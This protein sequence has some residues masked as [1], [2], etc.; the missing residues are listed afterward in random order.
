VLRGAVVCWALLFAGLLPCPRACA[1]VAGSVAVVSDYRFRGASLS[2]GKPALQLGL[3]WEREDGW[4]AGAFASSVRLYAHADMQ[5]LAYLGYARRLRDG[6]SWE[7]GAEYATFRRYSTDNYP[8]LYVGLASER[9]SG[10]LYYAPRYFGEDDAVVYVELNA[11]QPL[12]AHWRL[13]GHVGWLQRLKHVEAAADEAAQRR[14]VDARVGIGAAFGKFD[15]QLARIASDGSRGRYSGY[16]EA[17]GG[18]EG[19]WVLSVSR[20]W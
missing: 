17:A 15:L 8:E 11:N 1:Q 9:L 7:A 14:R 5:L 20:A 10:R 12:D 6:L 13:L 4:Y 16:P 19:A 3:G 18:D 2:D